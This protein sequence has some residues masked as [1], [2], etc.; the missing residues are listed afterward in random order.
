MPNQGKS[1]CTLSEGEALLDLAL[2]ARALT[3][4]RWTGIFTVKDGGPG[5]IAVSGPQTEARE[6]VAKL[7]AERLDLAGR[8]RTS[9]K[10]GSDAPII[11]MVR[12]PDLVALLII[13]NEALVGGLSLSIA[14][15]MTSDGASLLRSLCRQLLRLI[16]AALRRQDLVQLESRIE[17]RQSLRARLRNIAT[18]GLVLDAGL[19][20]LAKQLNVSRAGFGWLRND[21]TVDFVSGVGALASPF[22]GPMPLESFVGDVGM[23]G[24]SNSVRFP[25]RRTLT[26]LLRTKDRL[27]ALFYA[28]TDNEYGWSEAESLVLS[29]AAE[30]IWHEARR[31]NAE[32]SIRSSE[33]RLRTVLASTSDGFLAIDGDWRIT[34]FNSAAEA[35]FGRASDR[36]LGMTL[37]DVLPEARGTL[38]Q[39]IY[40]RVMARSR[41]ESFETTSVA[42]PDHLVEVRVG[43]IAGAGL[44][45]TFSDI[46]A[47]KR[48]ESELLK[49]QARLNAIYAQTAAGIVESE[50]KGRFINAND[51]FLQMIGRSHE[52]LLT[53]TMEEITHPDDVRESLQQIDRNVSLGLPVSIIKRYMRADGSYF[54][55]MVSATIIRSE[56]ARPSAFAVVVDLSHVTRRSS[57]QHDGVADLLAIKA[58]NC[59]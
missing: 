23:L 41:P 36:V 50:L 15:S 59:A 28:H 11:E 32:E 49:R 8:G 17:F 46:T 4:A 47:R 26:I 27:D 37:Y 40:A 24:Q 33:A 53:L 52:E 9:A 55:A 42:R 6:A 3:D 54:P 10:P 38:F 13:R 30:C 48:A 58:N 34:V 57:P 29:D 19:K 14:S 51:R 12:K 39:E 16:D 31:A 21:H 1:T 45:I 2:V 25:S 56:V 35:F 20:Q 22:S 18:T 5:E 7:I 43:P 44:A